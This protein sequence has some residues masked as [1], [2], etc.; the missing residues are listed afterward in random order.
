MFQ[1]IN[2]T[3]IYLTKPRKQY[4]HCTLQIYEVLVGNTSQHKVL[5][6]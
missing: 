3:H 1:C 2:T 6:K 4:P 5:N